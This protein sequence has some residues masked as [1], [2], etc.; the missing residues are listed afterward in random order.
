MAFSRKKQSRS[1]RIIAVA[2]QKGGVGKTTTTVNLSAAL[3]D[4]G[5]RV[6]VVDLDPQANAT[7]GLGID[8]FAG[9][10]STYD[11]LL[12][13]GR[14]VESI[15][16]TQVENL[17][18][19]PST[20]DLAGAEIELVPAFSRER[21]L[22]SALATVMHDF[23]FIFVDCPPSLG[24]LTVNAMAAA[25]EVMVPIQCEYYALEGLG[26][27]MRNIDLVR[28]SLNSDLEISLIVLVMY[29][30]RTKLSA[31]VASEIRSYFGDKV[32]HQ[33]IPRNIRLAE[34][35]S[36]G[37]PVTVTHP[38]SRGALAY[39]ELAKEVVGG[40]LARVG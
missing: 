8:P 31:Q 29:D 5:Q 34:A 26:Q 13:N 3:A 33:M 7:T 38:R 10:V 6:L 25:R 12:Q 11:V 21:R 2:N 40:A 19:A 27:L 4:L 28:S 16:S 37:A 32:C 18:L 14:M 20:L 39:R 9:G 1:C 22:D 35:P 36:Y 23:D 24:L 17:W 30:G 15:V